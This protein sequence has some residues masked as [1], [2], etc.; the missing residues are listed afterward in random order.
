VRNIGTRQIDETRVS[1]GKFTSDVGVVVAN[2][3]DTH[4]QVREPLPQTALVEWTDADGRS[5][6]ETVEVSF[7]HGFKGVLVFDIDDSNHVHVLTEPPPQ[8]IVGRDGG[9]I[10]T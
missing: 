10:S 5:H 2:A 7:P 6:R 4:L 8:H 9:Q 1:Y 3:A